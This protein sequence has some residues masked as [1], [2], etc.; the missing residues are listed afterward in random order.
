MLTGFSLLVALEVLYLSIANLPQNLRYLQENVILI[1][2]IP[3][4][5]EPK[6]NID[7]Y[8]QPLLDELK[9]FWSGVQLTSST[10][11]T[12]TTRICLMCVSCDILAVR[13]VCSS[14]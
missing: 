12:F 6:L 1:G 14:I 13:K 11:Q 2:M 4:P 10:G 3:G 5:K 9:E 8:L 7:S